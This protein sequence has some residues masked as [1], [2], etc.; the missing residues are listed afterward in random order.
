MDTE[1]DEP[2]SI[3][4]FFDTGHEA[5]RVSPVAMNWRRRLVRFDKLVLTTIRKVGGVKL[6][7]LVCSSEGANFLLEYN[8]DNHLWR[9]KKVMSRD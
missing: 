7:D 3:W 4:A 8:S 5:T 6:M 2:V 9:L 1:V